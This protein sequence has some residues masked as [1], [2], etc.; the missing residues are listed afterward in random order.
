ML[1]LSYS[2]LKDPTFFPVS[3][4]TIR[5]FRRTR[6]GRGDVNGDDMIPVTG[7]TGVTGRQRQEELPPPESPAATKEANLK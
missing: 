1:S 6:S 5:I 2:G 4:E 3:A 7:V